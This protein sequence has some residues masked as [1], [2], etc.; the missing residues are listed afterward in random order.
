MYSVWTK[1]ASTDKEK[2][3]FRLQVASAQPVIK[4]LLELA[5]S[6]YRSSVQTMNDRGAYDSQSW[7][8]LQADLLGEQRA[9]RKLI[10]LLENIL[11]EE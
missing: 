6:E 8:F 3:E 5:E 11:I 10:K 9:Y 4:R 1:G 7:P 2:N